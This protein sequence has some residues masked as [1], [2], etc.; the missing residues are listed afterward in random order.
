RARGR[1]RPQVPVPYQV[2]LRGTAPRL[3]RRGA[4]VSPEG[5]RDVRV[6]APGQ[7]HRHADPRPGQVRDQPLYFHADDQRVVF[8]SEIK[9]LFRDDRTPR[10]LDWYGALTDPALNLD[11]T[12]VDGPVNTWF[13]DVLIVP[14]AHTVS[15][16]LPTGRRDVTRY[17][18]PH[19]AADVGDLS[20][21]EFVTTY[22]D[23]LGASVSECLTADCEVGML[24]SGGIDSAAVAAFAAGTGVHTFT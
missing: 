15:I 19:T 12:L 10:R 5:A 14:A 6:R 7:P 11:L 4:R 16:D 3:S 9:A 21:E 18:D 13:E 20:P 23:L 1:P 24:L 17:W 22:R 8:A 2:R